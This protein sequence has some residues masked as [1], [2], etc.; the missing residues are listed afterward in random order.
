MMM[1]STREVAIDHLM[2]LLSIQRAESANPE[3]SG[4]QDRATDV[5]RR[6]ACEAPADA[7]R[8]YFA[9]SDDKRGARACDGR[10]Y[11]SYFFEIVYR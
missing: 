6:K 11:F 9:C 1:P 8:L 4:E 3:R 7:R 10:V 2:N 5:A